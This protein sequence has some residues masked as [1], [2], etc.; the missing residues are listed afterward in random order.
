VIAVGLFLEELFDPA[1]WD[2]PIGMFLD[3]QLLHNLGGGF[4]SMLNIKEEE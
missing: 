1:F 3:Q 4:P 2:V